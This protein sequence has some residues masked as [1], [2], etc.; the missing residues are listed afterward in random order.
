VWPFVILEDRMKIEVYTKP[1]CIY[2]NRAKA[3]LAEKNFEYTQYM[4]GK[5][6]TREEVVAKF[7]N[8]RTVPII[9]VDEVWIGG[10]DQLNE[11]IVVKEV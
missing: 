11:M 8:A 9:V 7:P 3:L 2:C 4:I 1:D 5:D 10:Y 6:V